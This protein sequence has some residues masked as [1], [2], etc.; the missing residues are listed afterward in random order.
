MTF[1]QWFMNIEDKIGDWEC[2][3]R[4]HVLWE[5]ICKGENEELYHAMKQFL[6]EAFEAGK[7]YKD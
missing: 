5:E 4:A 1:Y 6:M 7:Q 3:T 2:T